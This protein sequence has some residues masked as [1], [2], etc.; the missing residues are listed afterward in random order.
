MEA[1]RQQFAHHRLH[2]FGCGVGSLA[3]IAG[4]VFQLPVLAISGA[5]VCAAFCLD[6]IR[7]MVTM[8]PKRG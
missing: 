4:V 1:L 8:R 7:M 5:V 2:L 6:M 3:L